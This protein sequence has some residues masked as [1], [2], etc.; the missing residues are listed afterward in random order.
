MIS[1]ET[2]KPSKINGLIMKIGGAVAVE[3][4]LKNRMNTAFN[5]HRTPFMPPNM[6]PKKI[7]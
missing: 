6:P 2:K 5:I 3:L 7:P 4:P 1:L